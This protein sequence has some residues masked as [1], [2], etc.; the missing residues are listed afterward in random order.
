[1]TAHSS[2]TG[3]DLHEPK[4]AATAATHTVYVA[5]GSGSGA[6]VKIDADNI[7]TTSI[8][9][10]NKVIMNV[11]IPDVSAADVLLVPV[12]FAATL[13]RVSG[14]LSA[15]IATA[16]TTLTLTN[17]GSAAIGTFT[18]AFSGSAEGDFY[19]LTPS[20]NNTFVANTYLKIV[21][22]GASTNTARFTMTLEFTMT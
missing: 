19:Q 15:A 8:K 13:T 10:S 4:G 11:T 16:D 18:V 21:C 17:N 14:T 2:L 22:D 12:P 5:D 20:S 6:W 9:N 7:D 3:A 1:M